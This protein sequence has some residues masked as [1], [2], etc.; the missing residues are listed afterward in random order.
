MLVPL[1][2]LKEIVKLTEKTE[3]IAERLLLSGTKVEEINK[4]G[5]EV[6][7]NLEITP[8]R[9]DT[10][11]ILGVAREAAALFGKELN[12][13]ATETILPLKIK[14]GAVDFKVSD[15]KLCPYYSIVKLTNI[16][17]ESS[18]GWI[19]DY[20]KLAS[21]RPINNIVDITN[22]V[23]LELGQPMHA[24]DAKK[25]VGKLVLRGAK[26][27]EAV[28]TLDSVERKLKKGTIIIEDSEKL[29]DLAG[30]MGGENSEIDD[31]TTEIILMVPIYD[32][33][34]IRK[35]SLYTNLRTEASNRFEKK[36]DP[37]MHVFAINRVIKLLTEITGATQETKITSVGYPV[38]NRMVELDQRLVRDI[39]GIN[40]ETRDIINLLS[41]LEFKIK[42]SSFKDNVLEVEIPSFRTDVTISEDLLEEIARIYGYNNFPRTL[43]IGSIPVQAENFATDNENYIRNYL[44]NCNFSESTGYSLVS[45]KDLKSL[46][47]EA[48]DALKVL[49]PTSSDF[50]FLRPSLF[51][52][53]LKAISTNKLQK[54]VSFFEIAKEFHPEIDLKTKLPMQK[55]S[56]TLM[57]TE[58]YSYLKGV[59]DNLQAKFDLKLSEKIIMNTSY[60]GRAV[61]Y[62]EGKEVIAVVGQLSSSVCK[63]FGISQEVNAA[64]VNYE[65]VTKLALKNSF[66]PL[67][68]FP[69]VIEDI[70][71]FINKE[72]LI[73]AIIRNIKSLDTLISEVEVFDTII[74]EGK[75]SVSV[76][77]NYLSNTR[78]LT[79]SEV[80]KVR[81]KIESSLERKFGA[82]IRRE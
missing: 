18:P 6:V 46:A 31:K 81:K 9:P 44:L 61:E 38:K 65:A 68:K 21:V 14:H 8:N 57:T 71:F 53:S 80:S 28:R 54:Q 77:I 42:V 55:T 24:F 23:M 75:K 63:N 27:G 35:T 16:K 1:S 51:I 50:V 3:T 58:N 73:G 74:R 5:K 36:L 78:T 49:Y 41:P 2:W 29:I 59:I 10:L 66:V 40:L 11:S 56:L 60:W 12:Y 17:L 72:T 33:V 19:K 45:E 48:K 4:V 37:N 15:K 62:S 34:I 13:P 20:L 7:F 52:N 76:R 25:I 43:P 22:F 32:P 26:E 69:A 79:N 82:E 47:L 70:S 39:L 67:P 30:L 64:W